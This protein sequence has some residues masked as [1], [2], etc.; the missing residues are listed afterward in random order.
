MPLG[1]RTLEIAAI[2][3]ALAIAGVMAFRVAHAHGLLLDDGQPIF[4]DFISF[5]SAGRAALDGHAARVHE[6]AFLFHYHQ[7]AV[8][9]VAYVA[10]FNSPPTFLLLLLALSWAPFPIAALMFLALSAALYIFAA[11]KLLPDARVL[12]F[13]LTM[14]AAFYHLGTVQT[15]LW[16]AGASGLALFWLDAKPARAGACVALLAIKPHLALLWPLLLALSGRWRA[17]WAATLATSAFALAAGLVFGFDAYPRFLANLDASFSQVSGQR[18]TTPA[19]ASLYGNLLDL[20][21]TQITAIAAQALSALAA[22]ALSGWIFAR[23]GERA[24]Q[25]AALCAATLLI[26]PYLFFYDFTLLGVGAALL[27]APRNRFEWAALVLAWSAG[28]SLA[29]G[30]LA[31]LPLCPLA[32]WCVLLSATLRTGSA[33]ARPAPTPRR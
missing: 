21:V 1:R 14:P 6:A 23:G 29:L 12:I 22:L 27:G 20:G 16:I 7:A 2:A 5:W 15:G 31:P 32:A 33:V 24:A 10:P 9:G 30:Y 28:L 13:A 26:S 3:I 25:G 17:F 4:G 18:I 19:Y 11:R 8:P